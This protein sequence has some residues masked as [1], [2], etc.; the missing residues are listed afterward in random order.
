MAAS[1]LFALRFSAFNSFLYADIGEPDGAG[2]LTVASLFGR[3]G[4]DH[5]GLV[6]PLAHETSH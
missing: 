5:T 2:T 6:E 1:D 3:A 4:H